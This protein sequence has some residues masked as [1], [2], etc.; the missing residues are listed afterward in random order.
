MN[1]RDPADGPCEPNLGREFSL[2]TTLMDEDKNDSPN[3]ILLSRSPFRST[4]K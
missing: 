4:V 2:R 1:F 3:V